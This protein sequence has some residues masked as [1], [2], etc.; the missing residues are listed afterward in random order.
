MNLIEGPAD[1]LRRLGESGEGPCDIAS[2]ALML[3]VL[4]YS[5]RDLR[6][7][8]SHLQGMTEHAQTESRLAMSA[9]DGARILAELLAGRY[10]YDGDR[11]AYDDPQNANLISVIDRRRGL[12]VSLGILYLHAA[13]AAGF[14]ASGLKSPGHFLLRIGLRAA[15]P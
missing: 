3:A 11:L 15:K 1:Y 2:A 12:P 14:E 6:P 7:Y 13:R 4:D 10:G 5:G 9:D 8:R